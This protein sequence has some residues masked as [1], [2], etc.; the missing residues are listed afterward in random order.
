MAHRICRKKRKE[1]EMKA[2]NNERDTIATLEKRMAIL[3]GARLRDKRNIKKAILVQDRLREKSR[4]W[5]GVA[6]IRKWR[7]SR[8]L[9]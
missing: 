9:S 5:D 2:H 8:C 6:E 4:G 7:D 3:T 1:F